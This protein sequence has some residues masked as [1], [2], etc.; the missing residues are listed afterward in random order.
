MKHLITLFLFSFYSIFTSAQIGLP[1]QRSLIPKN[2]LVVNYDFSK[3][4]GFTRGGT[5]VTNLAGTAS[6]NATLYNAPFFINSLGYV[7]FNGSN[8][9]LATPNI[10]TY[11]KSAN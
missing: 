8:Q 2:N 7:S 9:Y 6:G 1:I 11:F 10:R 5:A 4:A 3:S